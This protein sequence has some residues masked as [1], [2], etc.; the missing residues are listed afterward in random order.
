MK[1]LEPD[2]LRFSPPGCAG[3]FVSRTE[4]F[5][6]FV[7]GETTMRKIRYGFT[8]AVSG[9]L[10]FLVATPQKQISIIKV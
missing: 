5:S 6:T 10:R 3:F 8:V 9:I 4:A 1:S 2:A 7:K